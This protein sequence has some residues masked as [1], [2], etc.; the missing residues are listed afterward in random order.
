[1]K[2][3]ASFPLIFSDIFKSLIIYK[4]WSRIALKTMFVK[5]N[6]SKLGFL[7]PFINSFFFAIA[8]S[9]V[10]SEILNQDFSTYA[11]YLIAGFITWNFFSSIIA[12]QTTIFTA[13]S[14]Y[15]KELNYNLFFYIFKKSYELLFIFVINIFIFIFLSICF[16]NQLTFNALLL[17]INIPLIIFLSIF[18]AYVFAAINCFFRDFV[19]VM[20]N[21]MRLFFF[22]TPI[23]W[24]AENSDGIR[25]HLSMYNPFYYLINLIRD[26]LLS[27]D[28]NE[29]NYIIYL[30]LLLFFFLFSVILFNK[31]NKK[32]VFYV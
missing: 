32:I 2:F 5:Y 19:F 16:F 3:L 14:S 31:V 20:N 17:L 27:N 8:I 25:S 21:M 30:C 10:F 1:M 4:I 15:L 24:H 6:R 28:F 26:P 9:V 22:I 12:E 7:W 23:L 11:P 29:V 13:N 18:A